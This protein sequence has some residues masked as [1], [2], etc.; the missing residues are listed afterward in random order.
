MKLY[1]FDIFGRAE[2]IRI[3]LTHSKSEWQDVRFDY[4]TFSELK[5][6]DLFE[7]DQ[8]PMLEMDGEKFS[9]SYSIL[10]LLGRKYGYYPEDSIQAYKVDSVLQAG[11]DLQ[12]SY[13]AAHL[14]TEEVKKQ[15]LLKT[16]IEVNLSRYLKVMQSRLLKNSNQKYLVN[17]TLTIADF[18]SAHIAKDY[19]L[20]ESFACYKEQK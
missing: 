6:Q 16:Y 12:A 14:A 2:P 3:L 5:A 17:D 7:F 9:Q 8:V 15:E 10:R 4:K 20:N 13:W 18:D 1:Y 19:I 11:A